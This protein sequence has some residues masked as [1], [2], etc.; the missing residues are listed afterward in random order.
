MNLY[1]IRVQW[2]AI[3]ISPTGCSPERLLSLV[4]IRQVKLLEKWS[5]FLDDGK[6][7]VC[8]INAKNTFYL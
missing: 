1:E 4:R 6:V 2:P 5:S 7:A 8:L 3:S